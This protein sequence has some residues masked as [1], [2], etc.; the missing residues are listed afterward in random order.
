MSGREF[1]RNLWIWT[2]CLTILILA[3]MYTAIQLNQSPDV[4]EA[5]GLLAEKT[6]L[7]A[8]AQ[9][10]LYENLPS[11]LVSSAYTLLLVMTGIGVMALLLSIAVN[12]F[13]VAWSHFVHNGVS[14]V[15]ENEDGQKL[16]HIATPETNVAPHISDRFSGG[17]NR[18]TYSDSDATTGKSVRDATAESGAAFSRGSQ[19]IRQKNTPR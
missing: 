19:I 17:V 1:K 14:M 15:S 4:L 2:I 6:A 8:E 13:G 18:V 12:L 5:R 7:E 3:G 9:K 10:P 16:L 11:I